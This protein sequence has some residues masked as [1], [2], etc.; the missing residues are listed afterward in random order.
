MG[1]RLPPGAMGDGETRT[2]LA[3]IRLGSTNLG[4]LTVATDAPKM[5]VYDRLRRLRD[6]GLVT[7]DRDRAGTIRSQVS[8]RRWL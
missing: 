4:E 2:V 8:M 5:T 6:R 3:V 7:W 1:L